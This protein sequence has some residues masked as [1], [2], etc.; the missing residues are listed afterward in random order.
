MEIDKGERRN[1]NA[2][3]NIHVG[4]GERGFWLVTR[5][6]QPTTLASYRF[7]VHA[8]AFARAVAFSQ[9]VEMVVHD[10]NGQIIRHPRASLTY[11]IALN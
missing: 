3:K 5:G 1:T 8:M 11:P 7:K 9:H 6:G 4:C 10:L 2:D